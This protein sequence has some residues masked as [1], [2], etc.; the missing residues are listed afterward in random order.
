M[1]EI[2]LNIINYAFKDKVDKGGKPYINHL[3]RV[4]ENSKKYLVPQKSSDYDTLYIVALLHDLIED[5][6]EWKIEH[7][8]AIFNDSEITDAVKRLTK[9]K[10]LTYQE[11]IKRVVGNRFSHAVK[12]SDLEDNM[13]LSRISNP[14]DV[15]LK[16]VEK[17]NKAKQYL[18]T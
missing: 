8:Q 12:L 9:D 11:N 6:V 16:R 10:S 5:C 7:I 13:D 3:Y 18:K 15:D 4:A 1:K 2:A 14:T 17:Y